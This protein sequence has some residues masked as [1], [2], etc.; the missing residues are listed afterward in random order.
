METGGDGLIVVDTNILAYLLIDGEYTPKAQRLLEKEPVWVAPS[1]W[2]IEFM[3]VLLNYS[4]YSHVP[5]KGVK[6]IWEMSFHLPHLREEAV[7]AGGAL[8]LALKHGI[9]GYDALFV[10]LARDLKTV[11]VTQDKALRKAAPNLTAT[12]EELFG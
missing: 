2:R 10:T 4:Q 1:F 6:Q 12:M 7:E 8:E 9:T 5:P 3:N 11:C